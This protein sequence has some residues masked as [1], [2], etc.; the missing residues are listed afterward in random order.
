MVRI[1]IDTGGTFTDVFAHDPDTGGCAIAKVPST[2]PT[3]YEGVVHGISEVLRSFDATPDQVERICYGTTIAT[4]AILER[5]GAKI[6]LLLTAGHED[7]LPIGKLSRSS[8]YDIFVEAAEPL[9]LANRQLTRGVEERMSSAGEPVVPLSERNLRRKAEELLEQGAEALVVSFIN[10]Y[11]NPAHEERAAA[12]LRE[13]HPQCAVTTASALSRRIGEYE[14]TVLAS[15]DAYIRPAIITHLGGLEAALADFGCTAP[16]QIMQSSGGL[17]GPE[18]TRERPIG[19]ALSGPA[20]GVVG[21]GRINRQSGSRDCITF[22]MGGTSTDVALVRDAVPLL[23]PEGEIDGFPLSIPMV[24]IHTVGAGGGSI[25]WIDQGGGLQIGPQSAGARPGPACYGRGGTQPTVTD[26]S[27]VL[28]YMHSGGTLQI[29]RELAISAIERD[30]AGP[31]GMTVEQAALGI[32]RVA[33]AA[34]A[35]AVR[36]VSVAQ[37]YDPRDLNL[38]A[39]GGAGPVHAGRLAEELEIPAVIIPPAAGVLCAFG[40]LGADTVHDAAASLGTLT[41]QTDELDTEAVSRLLASLDQECLRKLELDG[42]SAEASRVEVHASMRY[43]GQFHQLPVSVGYPLDAVALERARQA[44]HVEH[45]KVY[46]YAKPHTPVE[47][48]GARVTRTA[49][50]GSDSVPLGAA[51]PAGGHQAREREV[52]FDVGGEPVAMMTQV[53]SRASLRTGEE[54]RGPAVI[55]Q[56]D[57]TVVV[58]PGHLVTVLEGG[59]LRYTTGRDDSERV[60]ERESGGRGSAAHVDPIDIAVL[61]GLFEST[62]DEMEASMCRTAEGTMIN[63]GHDATAAIFDR[64]GRTLAQ[65]EALP[66]HLGMLVDAV[67][68][69]LREF[70]P[71][72]AKPGDVYLLNDPYS[73]GTHLP[74]FA[75]LEPVFYDDAVFAYTA[76]MAHHTDIGGVA[77]GSTST[78]A[79]DIHAEGFRLPPVRIVEAGAVD[80]KLLRIFEYNSR[81]GTAVRGDIEAQ[82]AACHVG[83]RRL[84]EACRRWGVD[85][86]V[87]VGAELMDIAE[88]TA[89]ES[90]RSIP[91]G[92]HTFTDYIDDDGNSDEPIAITVTVTVDGSDIRF[93]FAGTSPQVAGAINCTPSSSIAG[94]YY[95]V[96]ILCPASMPSNAGCFRSVAVEM[97]EGSIVNASYPAPV[98]ARAVTFKRVASAV[99]GALALAAPERVGAPGDGQLSMI[100]VGDRGHVEPLGLLHCGGMGARPDRDGL[101]MTDTDLTNGSLIPVE[102]TESRLPVRIEQSRL[103]ADSGGA[104]E[105]RGGLGCHVSA[106]WLGGDAQF[107]VRRDRHVFTPQGVA[108]GL[109]SPPCRYRVTSASGEQTELGSKAVH[110][111]HH[112]EILEMWTTGGA[113]YGKPQHRDPELVAHDV[114]EGRVSTESAREVYR[115]ALTAEHLVDAVETRGLRSSHSAASTQAQP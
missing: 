84:E 24:G 74:D 58:Y 30:I 9:F 91:D 22:D 6:G 106:R 69:I 16:L 47:V 49:A 113:G 41:A 94:V 37:G 95:G 89:R 20:A 52:I 68:G 12:I 29:D 71:E 4:N 35:R 62:A 86:V 11:A 34:M 46:A 38:V 112:G 102:V 13:L 99:Q 53:I 51:A 26:A 108:G 98:G 45:E 87:R 56:T 60:G 61:R 54:V 92:S 100:Y 107:S 104:G 28:G 7:V 63:Q 93:D 72:S 103:W 110:M 77:P 32:H 33:N 3:F 96:R 90:I 48:A 80:E 70:P 105:Y 115:V 27:A 64:Q 15:F 65:A 1:G 25:A 10:S 82:I 111:F 36:L 18:T 21:A 81:N 101:D 43:R 76:T 97:P 88:R 57:A 59:N 85:K 75:V 42:Y 109:A 55:A 5:K 78:N 83:R 66:C 8:M 79:F 73:G 23:T 44:F 19:T 114:R 40:A 50:G 14:R 31:L 17:A 39:F 2:P 67:A